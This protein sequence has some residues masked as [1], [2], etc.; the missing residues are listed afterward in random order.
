MSLSITV[1]Q[2]EITQEISKYFDFEFDGKTAFDPPKLTIP[3]DFKIGLIVG[4]SG[5]GKSTLLGK[6][7][8]ISWDESAAICSHFSDKHEAVDRLSGVGLNSI[9]SWLRPYHVLSTGEKFRADLARRIKNGARIDE[10]TSVVDRNVAKSC[11]YSVNRMVNQLG[12]SNIVF[13]SCHYDIIE[14]LQP[15]WVFDTAVGRLE[16]SIEKKSR[17]ESWKLCLAGAKHGQCSATITISTETSIKVRD[18]GLPHGM[19]CQLDLL[20]S[21]HSQVVA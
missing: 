16:Q 17:P 11:A 10:F 20:P 1:K 9:P 6:E 18:A 21:S 4:P 12:F 13:A 7:E 8:I 2:D 15:D 5:S 14:W 19:E 3:S